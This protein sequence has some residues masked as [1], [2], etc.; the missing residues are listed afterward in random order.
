MKK[1][2]RITS[3]FVLIAVAIFSFGII[4]DTR[5]Q[6]MSEYCYAPL[7]TGTSVAP[8]IFLVTDASG[9]MS[10]PAYYDWWLGTPTYS[11]STTYEGYFTPTK[12]YKLTSGVWTETA[13]AES[14]SG[15]TW[16]WGWAIYQ[17]SGTCSGSKLNYALMA[18]I[19]IVRWA[20]TGGTPTTCTG[21]KTFNA[22][23]CDTE[24]WSQPGNGSKVGSVCDVSGCKI[25]TDSDLQFN[26]SYNTIQVP[27]SRINDSLTVKFKSLS[28]VPRMGGFF[29]SG[30]GVRSN[31]QVYIGDFTGPNSTASQFPFMNLATAINSTSP[32]GGTPT[33]PA[34]WDALNYYRQTNPQYGGIPVQQGSGD[35]WKN[36]MYV[37]D[38]G[39][40]NCVLTSCAKNFAILLSD[41]QWNTPGCSISDG[42]SDPVQPAYQMHNG[43]TNAGANVAT[44]V[45][46]VYS[47]G[48]FLGG[49]GATSLQNVAMYGSFD[50]TGRTWPDSLSNYPQGTCTMDD[51]WSSGKGSGCTALP[52]SSLDWDANQNSVP[53]TYYNASNATAIKDAIMSAVLDA[54][55]RAS[56]GTTVVA[57]PPTQTRESSVIAQAYLYPQKVDTN[58]VILKWIGYL[59]LFWADTTANLR[60]NTDVTGE[61]PAKNIPPNT[62]AVSGGKPTEP[63]KRIFDLIKDKVLAFIYDNTSQTYVAKVYTDVKSDGSVNSCTNTQETTDSIPPVWEAGQLLKYTSPDS[64]NIK[65]WFDTNSNGIVD[66][67]EYK[68]FDLTD[69]DATVRTTLRGYWN[70]TDLGA[71]DDNCAQS[72]IKYARGYDRPNPSG[73]EHSPGL[74]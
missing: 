31:G 63:F 39:G 47:I 27:W 44:N 55:R 26:L 11:S 29:F 74:R 54:L 14:C 9:S 10:W 62:P 37:C 13:D 57:L 53:D 49:T 12:N 51:C 43:F 68:N 61:T 16:N 28:V 46:A 24:L 22:S 70:Y 58:N 59:R 20:I 30:S 71:C 73:K 18:R 1:R 21:T 72:V 36:P 45:N 41:G 32:S 50:K 52:A 15:P 6:S 34:M 38:G 7:F 17:I 8:N 65:T 60:E 66:S 3:I 42:V 23:Y 33:G 19:D 4:S 5:S 25:M 48:I 56:S 40:S 35:R 67:G 2:C 69:L 64:R